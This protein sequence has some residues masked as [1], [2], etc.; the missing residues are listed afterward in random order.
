M[1][2]TYTE[3]EMVSFGNHLLSNRRNK[4]IVKN[5]KEVHQEDLSN[6]RDAKTEK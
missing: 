5:K 6:W 3:A 1:S 2:K 4:S